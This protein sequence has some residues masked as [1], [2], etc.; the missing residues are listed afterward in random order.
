[1]RPESLH[2][3][4]TLVNT[5]SPVGH[6]TRGLRAWLDYVSPYS[7]ETY[8]DA[9]GNSV[10]V[11]NKGGS[12]RVMLAAHADEIAM[13]VNY[14]SPEG[15]IYVRRTGGIDAGIMRAQRVLIHS[16]RGPVAGVIGNVAPHLTKGEG[17]PKAPK[18]HELFLDIGASTKA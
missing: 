9:Y 11:L 7:D 17:D 5:P 13:T 6:E 2:F 10:A 14:I 15:F 1:M 16:R 3:L 4:E 18:I 12:P 8:S